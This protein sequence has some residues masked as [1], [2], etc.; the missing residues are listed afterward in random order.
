M[1]CSGGV[2]W[3]GGSGV[4]VAVGDV[5]QSC[6][7]WMTARRAPSLGVARSI[8]RCGAPILHS[9][10]R[11]PA[12]TAT[13]MGL[14]TASLQA[15]HAVTC[16][17][18][19]ARELPIR[20]PTPA[21]ARARPRSTCARPP[22]CPPAREPV[23]TASCPRSP[24]RGHAR[25]HARACV[26]ACVRGCPAPLRCVGKQASP[27]R[28]A[29]P[30]WAPWP[31][32]PAGAARR[33]GRR[34]ACRRAPR[35]RPGC[36]GGGRGRGGVVGGVRLVRCVCCVWVLLAGEEMVHCWRGVVGMVC[37]C[38]PPAG[39][40]A[41]PHTSARAAPER[42]MGRASAAP[43]AARA[44]RRVTPR[45]RDDAEPALPATMLGAAWLSLVRDLPRGARDEHRHGRLGV[46]LLQQRHGGRARGA[47]RSG[48]QRGVTAI[49]SPPRRGLTA[50]WRIPET[51]K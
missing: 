45:A 29:P 43:P 4:E 26:R 38:A 19:P 23:H 34:P 25:T 20:P 31:G 24:A 30:A 41:A 17:H 44:P 37:W 27:P 48:P 15:A 50:D 18:L 22:A 2:W 6:V 47:A 11:T 12:R 13:C 49:E 10:T 35:G 36:G 7:H 28:Y 14:R 1:R 16:A 9:C 40:G 46:Q 8:D 39:G 42:A 21:R 32:C 3:W 5:R 51:P 33:A